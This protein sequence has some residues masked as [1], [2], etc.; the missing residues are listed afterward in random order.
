MPRL[1]NMSFCRVRF[2]NRTLR[3]IS[4]GLD[5]N[6]S[7]ALAPVLRLGPD[8]Q[9][10]N[11]LP[12]LPP[13]R[14]AVLLLC[15]PA[16]LQPPHA[17]LRHKW[18]V[19]AVRSRMSS[20]RPATPL[21][22]R[23]AQVREQA[24]ALACKRRWREGS[25]GEGGGGV[26]RGVSTTSAIRCALFG[27]AFGKEHV[28]MEGTSATCVSEP[29][30]RCGPLLRELVSERV[31]RGAQRPPSSGPGLA[32]TFGGV[33]GG[34]SPRGLAETS[35]SLRAMSGFLKEMLGLLRETGNGAAVLPEGSGHLE[36]W[37]VLWW[38]GAR[39]PSRC[40]PGRG[41]RPS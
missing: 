31:V 25:S 27:Q 15:A 33:W 14:P 5:G 41:G 40:R 9:M 32:E 20:S 8:A 36:G 23:R 34:R 21:S 19:W 1:N 17:G 3:H 39:R 26:R 37:G 13:S 18:Q 11:T 24:C 10:P 35:G 4:H 38:E 7:F 30:W 29:G 16:A 2:Y 12:S 6:T 28:D 22:S